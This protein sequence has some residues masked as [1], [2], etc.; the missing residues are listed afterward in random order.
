M[1]KT[2]LAIGLAGLLLATVST[3]ASAAPFVPMPK[4]L[5]IERTP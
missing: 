3:S 2:A 4:S 1:P 5:M